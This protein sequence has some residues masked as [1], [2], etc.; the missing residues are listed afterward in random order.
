MI[1]EK[2]DY[3]TI[4]NFIY[5]HFSFISNSLRVHFLQ[6]MASQVNPINSAV[7]RPVSG[8]RAFCAPSC[9][10]PRAKRQDV[11]QVKKRNHSISDPVHTH[12]IQEPM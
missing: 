11:K 4:P 1:Y 3:P 6:P 8:S 2:F 5:S 9:M 10:S 12:E 7:R